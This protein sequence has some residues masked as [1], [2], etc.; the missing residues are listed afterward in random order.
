MYMLQSRSRK[1]PQHESQRVP[2]CTVHETWDTRTD[3]SCWISLHMHVNCIRSQQTSSINCVHD[4]CT[5]RFKV[6]PCI[7]NK[8][9]LYLMRHAPHPTT[10]VSMQCCLC[11]IWFTHMRNHFK[12]KLW[13]SYNIPLR[14]NL[15]WSW[16]VDI[17]H[18]NTSVLLFD[19]LRVCIQ[20][21]WR[22][23]ITHRSCVA[24]HQNLLGGGCLLGWNGL[25]VK[26][27]CNA[28]QDRCDLNL[29][30]FRSIT[31]QY[32]QEAAHWLWYNSSSCCQA[33]TT[34]S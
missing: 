34:E 29:L 33:R 13:K 18:A 20:S 3:T 4:Y 23:I 28:T 12:N 9:C 27:S 17:A 32:N 19:S 15:T 11:S 16:A 14:R 7:A 30:C 31:H 2:E 22:A 24:T 10:S 6:E 26:D 5:W 25:Q 8:C 21:A 1:Y